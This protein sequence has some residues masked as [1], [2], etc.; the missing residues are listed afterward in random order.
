[1]SRRFCTMFCLVSS[2]LIGSSLAAS[3]ASAAPV[4]YIY[5][6]SN[7][8]G[9][10]NR[11]VA[12]AAASDGQLKLVPG[13]PFTAN[14]ANMAVNGKYLF[15][16]SPTGAAIHSFTIGSNGAINSIHTADIQKYPNSSCAAS[17]ALY[18]DRTGTTLYPFTSIADCS[19]GDNAFQSLKIEESTGALAYMSETMAGQDSYYPLAFMANNVYAYDASCIDGM[20]DIAGYKR[21]SSGSLV[22]I[23][24]G[25]PY[26][27]APHNDFYCPWYATADNAN[28]LAIDLE[29]VNKY[30]INPTGSADQIATYTVNESNGNLTTTSTE[31]NMPHTAVVSVTAMKAAPSGKLLAVGGTR[32]LQ[33]FHFNGGGP[34]TAAT[35]LLTSDEIDQVFWDN[36]N[37]LYAISTSHGKLFVFT[38][39]GTSHSQA[40]GSPY[41]VAKPQSLVVQ[42]R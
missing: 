20:R 41:T 16:S 14:L 32:G 7:Y 9:S 33:I 22:N 17:G 4:A 36:D 37:H 10:A 40:P 19:Y 8:A 39:S 31:K 3:A 1:M 12:Y 30:T 35:G 23:S 21:K 24:I 5:V 42:P 34:L 25:A 15:G 26:P 29:A 11:I 18:L 38:V 27:T 2:L 13:S 6:S 28:H